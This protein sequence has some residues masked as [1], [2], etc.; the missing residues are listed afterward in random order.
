MKIRSLAVVLGMLATSGPA[1]ADDPPAPAKGT[2][3]GVAELK[4]A[5][6]RALM[7]DLLEYLKANPKADDR[8]QAYMT[9]FDT[10][11]EHDW[12]LDHEET[13]RRYL[14]E[15]PEGAVRALARIVATMARAQAGRFDEAYASFKEL[16]A[17]LERGDQEEFASSFADS[18]ANAASAAG[19]YGVARRVYEALLDRF[20]ER[21]ELRDK[22]KDDLSRLERIGKPA[23]TLVV[24]DLDGKVLRLSDYRGKYVL[25]DFWA[26]WCAPCV[27]DLP[28]LQAAYA[29]YHARGFEVVSISLD[30]TVD[31]LAD[32]VKA[33]KLPW[34]QIHNA[35]C[36]GDAVEA[37]G[38]N[39]IP[40]TFL[41]AP[42]G[43]LARIELR[44][45]ALEKTLGTLIK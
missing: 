14:A 25:V 37:F 44:G 31:P 13:A 39:N 1:R 45:P 10:A 7:R 28:A 11:I 20:G 32:F 30:E 16:L 27:A 2:Y 19:E 43:T 38:V 15:N 12:F 33:R 29:R 4:A 36:G 24:K 6:D 41:V 18:L 5:H 23:P 9:L 17:G 35:T 42:D 22:V 3:K 34:R 40:A 26:T 8:E 21:P